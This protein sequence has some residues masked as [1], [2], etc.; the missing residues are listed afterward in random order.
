MQIK[1][2]NGMKENQNIKVHVLHCGQ[3]QVDIA[4][5]F[6]QKTLNPFAYA[7]I[8][9]GKKH[10]VI[11]PVSAYLIEHPKGLILIDAGWHPTAREGKETFIKQNGRAIYKASKPILPEGQAINEQLRS[12]GYTP[13][14]IDYVL[15]THLDLDHV[16]G[17]ELVK[18]AKNIWVSSEEW[19]AAHKP[20]LRYN[21]KLWEN[22]KIE[23]FNFQENGIGP[24]KRSLDLFGDGSVQFIS[25]PGH[26][27]GL[28]SV[29]V[30]NNSKQ[31]LI[32][33]DVGY[34]HKSWEEMIL[35]GYTTSKKQA[36]ASLKWVREISEAPNCLGIFATHDPEVKP[37]V[38]EL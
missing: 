18:N 11:V 26:T 37:Q 19:K 10:Q 22:T 7:G 15:I 9:R 3:V 36:F 29:L 6:K 34:A 24:E 12:L 28:T 2:Q 21:S 1:I 5:P 16:G 17:L 4:T 14:D 20:S 30:Q 27:V 33:A 25:T 31:L 13:E 8:F 35:P 38:V 32:C 23:P